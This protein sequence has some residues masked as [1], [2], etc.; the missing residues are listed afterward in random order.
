MINQS[1]L[2]GGFWFANFQ[3]Y[4]GAAFSFRGAEDMLY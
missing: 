4:I 3:Q 1:R 2:S